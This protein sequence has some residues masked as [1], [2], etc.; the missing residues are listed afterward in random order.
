MTRDVDLTLTSPSP[1]IPQG[2]GFMWVL[3]IWGN[4]SLLT[5]S[6]FS[7]VLSRYSLVC[8]LVCWGLDSGETRPRPLAGQ[9]GSCS[10]EVT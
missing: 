6:T 1:Q 7:R 8:L 3:S 10:L 4:Y 5:F 2:N 9:E